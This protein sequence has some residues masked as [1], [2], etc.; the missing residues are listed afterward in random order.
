[1]K[2]S[3]DAYRSVLRG[4]RQ[5]KL[6]GYSTSLRAEPLEDRRLLTLL[7]LVPDFPITTYDST[8]LVAY[9]ATTNNFDLVATPL[10]FKETALSPQRII[11][12]PRSFEIHI[13]VDN[14]G[15]LI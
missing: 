3:S 8:G 5:R 6:G 13:Q 12:P 9:S 10:R 14:S 2:R 7:G 15:N 4:S 11:Q 1:M